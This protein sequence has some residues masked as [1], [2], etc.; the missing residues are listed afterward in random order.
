MSCYAEDLLEKYRGNKDMVASIIK[1]K[2]EL[3]MWERNP[4][5]KEQKMYHCWDATATIRDN[6]HAT[7]TEVT[8]EGGISTQDAKPMLPCS[9][10]IGCPAS[11]VFSTWWFRMV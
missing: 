4:D 6:T 5:Y 1:D 11:H 8:T 10:L 3:G 7:S 2:E 9:Q